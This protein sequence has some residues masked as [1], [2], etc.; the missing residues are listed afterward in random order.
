M[1]PHDDTEK[2]YTSDSDLED[3]DYVPQGEENSDS[4]AEDFTTQEAEEDNDSVES[5]NGNGKRK[6]STRLNPISEI[7]TKKP[8]IQETSNDEKISPINQQSKIDALWA[9]FNKEEPKIS[10]D[11]SSLLSPLKDNSYTSKKEMTTKTITI[12]ETFRFAG[13]EITETREVDADSEE[14]KRFLLEQ[15]KKKSID[16]SKQQPPLSSSS[17]HTKTDNDDTKEQPNNSN[18]N[19]EKS[20]TST[21]SNQSPSRKASLIVS[22]NGKKPIRP[23]S[24]LDQL[25]ASLKNKPTKINTLDKSKMDWNKFVYKEG[26]VDEL[27]YHNKSGQ[28]SFVDKQEFLQR[29]YERQEAEL[30]SLRKGSKD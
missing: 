28:V 11:T 30:K 13:E 15:E 17:S 6:K 12:T 24:N 20:S 18:N 21:S 2:V 10:T 3:A 14:A 8:R 16:Q 22:H 27:K 25:A 29:T 4:E 5:P 9:E 1:N 19:I 7:I 26:I 23:K